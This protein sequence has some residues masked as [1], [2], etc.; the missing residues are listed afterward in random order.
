MHFI[1]KSITKKQALDVYAGTKQ[2][3]T[4][5]LA[6]DLGVNPAVIRNWEKDIPRWWSIIIVNLVHPGKFDRV[7]KK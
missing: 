4:N 6:R 5:A 2:Q 1:D 3:K 7:A